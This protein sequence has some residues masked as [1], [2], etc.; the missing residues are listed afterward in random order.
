MI[1]RKLETITLLISNLGT[2]KQDYFLQFF[3]PDFAE[4]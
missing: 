4:C 3:L 2:M 1:E